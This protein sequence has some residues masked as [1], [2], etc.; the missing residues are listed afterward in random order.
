MRDGRTVRWM[1]GR[2]D[3]WMD[4]QTRIEGGTDEQMD[5]QTD[6][7]FYRDARTHKTSGWNM[8]HELN[9]V[10]ILMYSPHCSLINQ[11]TPRYN[12]YCVLDQ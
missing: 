3:G 9:N 11:S 5:G 4:G 6:T 8:N 2:R 7:T 10:H 1:D 12:D